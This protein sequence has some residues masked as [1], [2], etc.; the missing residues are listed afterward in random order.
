V[1]RFLG[2]DRAE[3]E[4]EQQ[5]ATCKLED[6]GPK[7]CRLLALDD[8]GLGFRKAKGCWPTVVNTGQA[9]WIV[10]KM[11][12][13]VAQG[14]L[15]EHLM[16]EHGQRMIVVM[17]AEDLRR[18]QV[19]VSRELS[20]ER[21]AQ[22]LYWELVHNPTVNGLSR[23]AHVVVSFGAVG[24]LL[25]SPKQ[26]SE[27][28]PPEFSCRLFFD[29][30]ASEMAWA[31][32]YPGGVIGYNTCLT[33][34]ITHQLLV[35]SQ[36]PDADHLGRAIQSG[37]AAMRELQEIGYGFQ[38]PGAEL[39]A[40]AF[41]LKEI[42]EVIRNAEPFLSVAAV[43]DPVLDLYRTDPTDLNEAGM[44]TIL[45]DLCGHGCAQLLEL[46]Q[47]IVLEGPDE[48]LKGVPLGKFGGLTTA[49]RRE[50]ESFRAIRALMVEYY[51]GTYDKP[52][53]IAVFGPPGSGKSF[54]VKQVAKAVAGDSMV[55]MTFNLSQFN[56][57]EALVDALHQVRDVGLGGKLPLVFW[58]EF[59]TVFGEPLGWLRYFLSPMQDGAFQE[60][61]ITH[62]IGRAIFVFAG[63][64][65][66]TMGTFDRSGSARPDDPFVKSKGPDFV[67][68]LKGFV[69]IMGPNPCEEGGDE[70]HLIRRA[71][72]LRGLLERSAGQ[73]FR[74]GKGK[75][76]VNIDLGVLRAFLRVG[77]YQH[78][79]RSM[80]AI[81]GMSTLAGRSAYERSSLPGVGQLDVHVNGREFLSLVQEPEIEGE[82]LEKL[83]QAVHLVYC[84]EENAKPNPTPQSQ[85][86]YDELD[87]GLK[88]LNRAY[89]RDIDAKLRSIGYVMMPARSNEPPF[90][91]PGVE[92]EALAEAEHDRWLRQKV[93]QG[94]KY[95]QQRDNDL[96]LNP[97][98]LPWQAMTPEE[99]VAGYGS[100]IAAAMGT[101]ALPE[102][103]K[104]KDRDLIE[105]IPL[106]LAEAGYTV[107]RL[108]AEGKP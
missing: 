87:E 60:G 107:V 37:I 25:L 80:E 68:R 38:K 104:R 1:R 78:G 91:F 102:E 88:A 12:S 103:E 56:D 5:S 42:A 93:A 8:A 85:Q 6:G 24:A 59:D 45:D 10:V 29:P 67:S 69:N 74:G 106:I 50:I 58:D 39:V 82:L 35:A 105:G 22:D 31:E 90:G 79:V 48:P 26:G 20:W 73:I 15:W 99:L 18:T 2:I 11:A 13:P 51:K 89:V 19:H 28:N 32:R 57:P 30:E 33:A 94:W 44:W 27:G 47:Q 76:T 98:L 63:G 17:T 65:S 70:H 96:R 52:I 21:T 92:L 101:M 84:R 83:A 3:G 54:G 49:D 7:S 36:D 71:I 43:R 108:Q 4:A 40:P 72:I 86:T 77:R 46:A 14:D 61:Q 16:R 64:T 41:P 75:G 9:D 53:S 100:E 23:C 55:E 34:A 81:I 95:G 66:H 97:A 62:P